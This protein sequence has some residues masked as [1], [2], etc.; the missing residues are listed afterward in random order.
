MAVVEIIVA[1]FVVSALY[2]RCGVS[3][4]WCF[5]AAFIPLFNVIAYKNLR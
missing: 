5:F 2:Y 3:S 1:T 4:V